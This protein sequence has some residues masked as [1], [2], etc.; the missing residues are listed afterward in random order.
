M[1]Q[2][3]ILRYLSSLMAK[4]AEDSHIV[5]FV[6]IMFI[7]AGT[8]S[9]FDNVVEDLIGRTIEFFHGAIVLGI[10]NLCMSLV[11]MINGIKSIQAAEKSLK[12]TSLTTAER[13]DL[14]EKQINEFKAIS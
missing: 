2:N 11:F 6:G 13:L 5:F 7:I 8:F 3:S 10:F 14:L 4:I 9:L 12:K 1:K